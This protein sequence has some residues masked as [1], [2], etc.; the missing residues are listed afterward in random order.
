MA[1]KGQ[2]LRP[3]REEMTMRKI[4]IAFAAVLVWCSTSSVL[5][6]DSDKEG[7][8]L[9][10]YYGCI[11]CH[12]AGGKSPVRKNIPGLAGKPAN[13]LFDKAWAILNGERTSKESQTME[14]AFSDCDV[15]P[16]REELRQITGWLSAL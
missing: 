12:G 14:A 5:A 9:F 16:T 6:I 7:A 1:R 4:F 13:K 11:G 15:P 2:M 10:I 8:R 3:E